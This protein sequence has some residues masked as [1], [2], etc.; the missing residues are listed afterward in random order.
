[1]LVEAADSD[2]KIQVLSQKVL[3]MNKDFFPMEFTSTIKSSYSQSKQSPFLSSKPSCDDNRIQMWNKNEHDGP[4]KG[5]QKWHFK[6]VS[7][8]K[9]SYFIVNK[10]SW[11]HQCYKGGTEGFDRLSA[12]DDP[13]NYE[14]NLAPDR[15]D[16]M[17]IF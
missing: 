8:T 17:Q 9:N 13:N 7:N 5:C 16:G 2:E 1:V 12:S 4:M 3:D 14:V 6:K 10:Y 11:S 15:Y